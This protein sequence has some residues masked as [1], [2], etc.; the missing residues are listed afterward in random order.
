M[1]TFPFFMG[2]AG[3][4]ISP[5]P[6]LFRLIDLTIASGKKRASI[7]VLEIA[8]ANLLIIAIAQLSLGIIEEIGSY[9]ILLTII[10]SGILFYWMCG[11]F[12]EK[13]N[14]GNKNY[15]GTLALST[16][17]S[18]KVF[19]FYL[20]ILPSFVHS[21]TDLYSCV[22]LVYVG[23]VCLWFSLII[24]LASYAAVFIV[25]KKNLLKTITFSAYLYFLLISLKSIAQQ[26]SPLT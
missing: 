6:T 13:K 7:G 23:M 3:I 19:T 21:N 11:V 26:L 8:A 12:K 18:A 20:I 16:F 1:M 24:Y 2:L 14:R 9:R 15:L 17:L 22:A 4:I 25:N 10:S 5:G